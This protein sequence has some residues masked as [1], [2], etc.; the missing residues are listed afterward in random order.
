MEIKI[1]RKKKIKSGKIT[2]FSLVDLRIHI[3]FF[4]FHGTITLSEQR[5]PGNWENI[6]SNFHWGVMDLLQFCLIISGI[7]AC[8]Q[9]SSLQGLANYGN[10]IRCYS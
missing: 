9:F 5:Q 1:L 3:I 8:H 10:P 4:I 2:F 6:Y 7:E